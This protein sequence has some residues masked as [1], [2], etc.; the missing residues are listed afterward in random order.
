VHQVN[1]DGTAHNTLYL[2]PSSTP[3]YAVAITRAPD[4]KIVVAG[5]TM[6]S[7]YSV[8]LARLYPSLVLDNS[9][10]LDG[11]KAHRVGP[12]VDVGPVRL[13]DF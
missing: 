9:F 7:P 13:A 5:F 12:L 4:D 6:G 1:A 11:L 2:S 8:A 3:D 10:S